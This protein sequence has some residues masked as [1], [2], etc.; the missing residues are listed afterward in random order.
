[1]GD[2][3]DLQAAAA[4]AVPTDTAVSRVKLHSRRL[5]QLDAGI[6]AVRRHRFKRHAELEDMPCTC[7]IRGACPIYMCTVYDGTTRLTSYLSWQ[8]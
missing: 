7:L 5:C 6:T 3:C 4:A 1:M 8:R 2:F